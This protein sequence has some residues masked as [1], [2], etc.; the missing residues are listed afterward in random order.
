ARRRRGWWRPE[1][2]VTL[3]RSGRRDRVPAVTHGYPG[4][5]GSLRPAVLFVR[6]AA[7]PAAAA[8]HRFRLR[9]HPGAGAGLRPEDALHPRPGD[10]SQL[11]DRLGAGLC[12]TLDLLRHLAVAR[13]ADGPRRRV[14]R[15]RR[16]LAALP[17]RAIRVWHGGVR[18]WRR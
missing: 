16:F 12:D 5:A 10:V 9:R 3:A 17:W 13:L 8:V 6:L 18:V 1:F 14:D 2:P 15:R 11:G 4:D 7:R